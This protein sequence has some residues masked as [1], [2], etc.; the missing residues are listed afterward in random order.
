MLVANRPWFAMDYGILCCCLL[1]WLFQREAANRANTRYLVAM[2]LAILS[3]VMI[4]GEH[5]PTKSSI[6]RAV[7]V[8]F[9]WIFCLFHL[10]KAKYP[11]LRFWRFAVCDI[12]RHIS[13]V[14]FRMCLI[15]LELCQ[16]SVWSIWPMT[17][18]R[19]HLEVSHILL[20]TWAH[21]S[22]C[23]NDLLS[24]EPR[25][26]IWHRMHNT[27]ATSPINVDLLAQIGPTHIAIMFY[28]LKQI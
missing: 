21:F 5:L 23:D 11:V 16:V 13:Q 14:E 12:L 4:D 25:C 28:W 6:W 8:D 15:L 26:S 9:W 17:S 3:T 18:S 24:L 20:L 27:Y 19:C 1:G 22:E 7:R 10:E 2:G